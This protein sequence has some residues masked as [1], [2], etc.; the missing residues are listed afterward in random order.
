[1]PE[2]HMDNIC[3]NLHHLHTFRQY[4]I[5]RNAIVYF[6]K[7]LT[8]NKAKNTLDFLIRFPVCFTLKS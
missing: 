1:M 3:D 8:A 5:G 7:A 2:N 6:M 4:R